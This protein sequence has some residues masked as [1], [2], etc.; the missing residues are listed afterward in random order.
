[1]YYMRMNNAACFSRDE[2][3]ENRLRVKAL[4]EK[5]DYTGA[6]REVIAIRELGMAKGWRIVWFVFLIQFTLFLITFV[7]WWRNV[8]NKQ[9][10]SVLTGSKKTLA[11]L[12]TIPNF[13]ISLAGII[14]FLILYPSVYRKTFRLHTTPLVWFCIVQELICIFSLIF[15]IVV[16][17]K[18]FPGFFKS[19]R[20][21]SSSSNYHNTYSSTSDYKDYSSSSSGSSDYSSSSSDSNSDYGG[22]GGDSGGG[23]ASSDW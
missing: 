12:V 14:V 2:K 16:L 13:F 23:G 11:G 19:K 3:E 20:P 9:A 10:P 1:M 8:K 22:G 4:L 7:T 15:S 18:F 17:N 5:G 6:I 21:G